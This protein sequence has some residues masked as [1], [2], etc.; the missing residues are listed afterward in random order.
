[1]AQRKRIYQAVMCT[2]CLLVDTF[3]VHFG[4]LMG[5]IDDKKIQNINRLVL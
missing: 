2:Q 4:V 3:T 5:F 1:M